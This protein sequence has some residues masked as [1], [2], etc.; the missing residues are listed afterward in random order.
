MEHLIF[1]MLNSL[2]LVVGVWTTSFFLD[3]AVGAASNKDCM[4]ATTWMIFSV[5]GMFINVVSLVLNLIV[6]LNT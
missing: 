3:H 4:V 5:F 1:V 2:A 6:F